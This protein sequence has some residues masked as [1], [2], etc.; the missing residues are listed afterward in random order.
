MDSQE[1]RNN[2]TEEDAKPPWWIEILKTL[3]LPTFLL[4]G[5]SYIMFE[6]VRWY[7]TTI[8]VPQQTAHDGYIEKATQIIDKMAT[9]QAENAVKLNGQTEHS[10]TILKIATGIEDVVQDTNS[11]VKI[12]N[13]RSKA[14]N[15]QVLKVLENIEENTKPLRVGHE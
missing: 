11:E 15:D 10:V 2:M 14:F 1:R 3:G 5:M 4:L 8:L 12:Q 6:G 9:L 7:A 13:E